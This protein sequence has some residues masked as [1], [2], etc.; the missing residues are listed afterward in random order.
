MLR[1]GQIEN[2]A[3]NSMW[4]SARQQGVNEALTQRQFPMMEFNS[5]FRGQQPQM[6]QF[7]GVPGVQQAGTNVAGIVDAAY[8]NQ[9][10][11]WKAEQGQN[12]SFMGGLF[13]LG[14]SILGAPMAGGGSAGGALMSSLLGFS[15]RRL[16]EN[17][18]RVGKLPSGL[19][20][21]EWNYFWGGP[22]VRGVMADEARAMFPD[23]VVSIGGF[24][25]VDYGRIG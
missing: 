18:E 17:V 8:Q 25:A 5:L 7:S 2:D 15:D 16:K 13:G 10:N 20:V 12:N 22:R 24:L 3:R 19:P 6:P 9:L 4:L 23:A 21:Y 14:G 11:A 1:Q